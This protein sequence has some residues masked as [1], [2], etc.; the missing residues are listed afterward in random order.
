MTAEIVGISKLFYI[1]TRVT[2]ERVKNGA[3]VKIKTKV[4]DP[5]YEDGL[6]TIEFTVRTNASQTKITKAHK[7]FSSEEIALSLE[8]PTYKP[9]A[10]QDLVISHVRE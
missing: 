1:F 8:S 4:P 2:S 5:A 7:P 10:D 3:E 6:A 9:F